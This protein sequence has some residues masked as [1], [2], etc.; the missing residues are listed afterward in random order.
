MTLAAD[1][2][3]KTSLAWEL[4]HLGKNFSEWL[5]YQLANQ[6]N[7]PPEDLPPSFALPEWI[8][9]LLFWLAIAAGV[10]WLTW[11]LVQLLD[12][13]SAHTRGRT[14]RQPQIETL[15]AEPERTVAAWLREARDHEQQGNWR[16]ACRAL[17]FAA[18][19]V[20]HDREW[21]PHLVS[22]TDG[23]YLQAIE[24]LKRRRPLQ[25][26]IR[27]HERSH[28]GADPLTAANLQHCRQ[29]YE[30]ITKR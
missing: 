4:R 10:L 19:Q 25:L 7:T 23:E 30:E 12:R 27:T 26:L 20:L 24:P 3:Q 1:A 15:I 5:Q 29:A 28:F 14:P 2:I 21:V 13:Y 22:R 8:G 17:Y 9:N 6:D 18:L 11:V 16:G